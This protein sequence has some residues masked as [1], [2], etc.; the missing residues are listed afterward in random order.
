[1]TPLSSTASCSIADRIIYSLN[2]PG[3]PLCGPQG[4]A[5]TIDK[6]GN[7]YGTTYCDGMFSLGSVFK[8]THSGGGWIYTSLYEFTGGATEGIRLVR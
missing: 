1:M 7:L 4:N 3:G 5:L 8:L 2:Q 6:A